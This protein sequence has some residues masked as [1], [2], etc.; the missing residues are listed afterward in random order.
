[1]QISYIIIPIFFSSQ[2]LIE[3]NISVR[4]QS[5]HHTEEIYY[6]ELVT[7]NRGK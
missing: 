7:K 5:C 2:F 6:R 3:A 4:V 1:M